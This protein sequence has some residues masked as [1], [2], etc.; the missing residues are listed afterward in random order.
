METT[1]FPLIFRYPLITEEYKNVNMVSPI[2]LVKF[3]A[4]LKA[5]PL[6]PGEK[7]LEIGLANT[8]EIAKATKPNIIN[9]FNKLLVNSCAL[10]S[11]STFL[12]C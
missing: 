6:S 1:K 12:P 9:I 8:K 5:S 4:R 2:I 3:A 10:S 7:A 11:P